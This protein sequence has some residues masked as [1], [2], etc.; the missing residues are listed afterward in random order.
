MFLKV[1]SKESTSVDVAARAVAAAV[2]CSLVATLPALVIISVLHEG[3]FAGQTL[4]GTLVSAVSAGHMT[5]FTGVK[6]RV[7]EESLTAGVHAALAR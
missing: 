1:L 6:S 3:R 2:T 7:V 4:S 5:R